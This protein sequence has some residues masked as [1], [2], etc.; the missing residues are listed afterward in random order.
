[1]LESE[2]KIC[3]NCKNLFISGM[4]KEW[5]SGAGYCKLIMEE[6]KKQGISKSMA[7]SIM[8]LN[9]TCSKFQKKSSR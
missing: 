8:G 5:D 3:K 4:F 7:K 1:M 2:K 6:I 9:D